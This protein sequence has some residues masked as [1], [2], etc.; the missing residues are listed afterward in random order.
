[1]AISKK[2]W[3]DKTVL[4]TGH[5][6]FKGGWLALWLKQLGAK[7]YGYSL[8]PNTKPNLFESAKINRIVSSTIN[9]IRNEKKVFEAVKKCKPQIIFH[10]AAQPLVRQSYSDPLETYQTN[11]LGTANILQ[12]IRKVNSVS[13]FVCITSDKCY[14]NKEWIWGYGENDHLGGF[15]PYSS[16]KACAELVTAAFRN[17][18]FADSKTAIASARAGNVVGGGDWADDRIVPDCIKC[19]QSGKIVNIRYPKATRPWQH[20]LEPLSGY[21]M[22]AQ[23]LCK[24]PKFAQPWNFGPEDENI[25]P[26]AKL[27]EILAE[28]W[29]QKAKWKISTKKHPHEASLL[30]LDC[31]KAKTLLDWK[32]CWDIEKTVEKTVDWY[33]CYY[34]KSGD[35]AEFTAKQI[36]EYT[37]DME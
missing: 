1:M 26:V 4:I 23:K 13:A 3:K 14:E 10:L 29:K 27:V 16:S 17:S 2:F 5:T 8:E 30:K 9:D 37:K 32:S 6:G 35:I 22:L 11:V 19:W 36:A 18:F 33:K 25:I 7:I 15:D 20:V 21:I 24:N 31:S 12:A 34:E 28:K